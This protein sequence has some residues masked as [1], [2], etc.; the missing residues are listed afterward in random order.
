MKRESVDFYFVPTRDE[1]NNEY[2]PPHCQRRTWLTHFTG[3]YGEAL[4]GLKQAFLWTDPRYFL[5]AEKELVGTGFQLMKQFQ[6]VSAPIPHWLSEHAINATVGVDPKLISLSQQ[7]Q[8]E[9]ALAQVNGR[10]MAFPDNWIDLLWTQ[11][12][13]PHFSKIHILDEKYTGLT[14]AEKLIQ[15]REALKKI[16]ADTL[17]ISQLDEIAWLFNIR[18]HDIPFN[19]LCTAYAIITLSEAFLFVHKGCV[20]DAAYFSHHHISLK[21]YDDFPAVLQQLDSDVCIDPASTSWWV[22]TQLS[23]ATVIKKTSPIVMLKAIKNNTE[24]KG[25]REAHYLDA[26]AM[27]KFLHWLE[28]HWYDGETEIT[29]ANQL[30]KFRKAEARCKD[31]SFPT[32]CGYADHGA[33]VHYMAQQGTAHA[34]SD[35]DLLLIDSG[36]QYFE[37]TTDIT[38]TLHLGKPT[39]QQ[40]KHY[41]LVLKGHLSLRHAQFPDGTCGEHLNAIARLPLWNEG[42]DFGHGTGHGVGC[43]LCV[44]E[45]PQRISGGA[46][47]VP[48]KPGMVVSNE[49]GV[50]FPGEYGIRIENVCA[51]V[52]TKTEGFYTFEDLTLVPYARNLIDKSLLSEEE[53][54]WIDE[55]HQAIYDLLGNALSSEEKIWLKHATAVL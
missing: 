31:L 35:S 15:V 28:A 19:P 23:K 34:I 29:V 6:G 53:I 25:M 40:K 46:S 44:H 18:G 12:P 32:I 43:Y 4:V 48:L 52:K 9:N 11:R 10:L 24:L 45:G 2:V 49:P 17:V 50:Y 41:T 16:H 39:L 51:I 21:S 3:S 38:R 5:Q 13:A 14:A 8:W 20:D 42:L 7:Q 36:G 27:V 26:I 47:G 22:A 33:I 30:E 37:G 1:H 55:Y 54:L